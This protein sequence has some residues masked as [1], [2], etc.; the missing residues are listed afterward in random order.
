[1]MGSR[2]PR[3]STPAILLSVARLMFWAVVACIR[4][5]LRAVK[6]VLWFGI[7]LWI[8]YTATRQ[9]RSGL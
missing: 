9:E 1:M 7:G 8:G 4:L 6:R 5:T 3:G 2:F